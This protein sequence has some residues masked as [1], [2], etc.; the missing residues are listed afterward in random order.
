METN[1]LRENDDWYALVCRKI[2]S[3][4][5]FRLWFP[6]TAPRLSPNCVF[7]DT[8]MAGMLSFAPMMS[9]PGTEISGRPLGSSSTLTLGMPNCCAV[10]PTPISLLR[11]F[12]RDSPKRV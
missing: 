5:T 1:W 9:R 4:P 6:R 10:L 11:M 8:M 2:T 7:C 12:S 3:N